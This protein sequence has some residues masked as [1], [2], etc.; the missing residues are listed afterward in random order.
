M[1]YHQRIQRKT[2]NQ[3]DSTFK[4]SPFQTHNFG[5]Q[6]KSSESIPATKVQLWENYQTAKQLHQNSANASLA[7]PAQ[8][9]TLPIQAKL[10]IGKPGDKYEQEAD[11]VAERVMSMSAPAQVQREELPEE[12]LQMKP[13]A[14]TI[15]PL[16]QREELPEEEAELQAKPDENA[17]QREVAPEEEEL[18]MKPVGN[19]I[20]REELP[21]DEEEIQTKQ[22][23]T[24]HSPSGATATPSL[25]NQLSSS[26]GGG[27]PLP[28][29]V[30]S[31]ME[32]R[33]GADFSGVRVHTGSDAVQ[34]NRDVS[35]QAFAH[36]QDVYFGAGKTP[37]K[38]SLTAHELTH[39]IQQ[40][41]MLQKASKKKPRKARKVNKEKG[42]EVKAKEIPTEH[43]FFEHIAHDVAYQDISSFKPS[44]KQKSIFAKSGYD[45]SNIEWLEGSND[46][47]ACLIFP[48]KKYAH[49]KLP[50][51]AVRGTEKLLGLDMLAN[52]DVSQ[53]GNSQFENNKQRIKGLLGSANGKVNIIGHSLGGAVAQIIAAH[54][55]SQ[56]AN[57]VTFQSP[58]INKATLD[59][60]HQTPKRDRP[61]SFHHIAKN[62]I[63]DLAGGSRLDG[64]VYEHELLGI[65]PIAAHEAFLFATKAFKEQRENLSLED[66]KYDKENKQNNLSDNNVAL[67]NSH[68]IVKYDSY[69]HEYKRAATEIARTLAGV[70]PSVFRILGEKAV[71]NGEKA[72]K[73]YE[74]HEKIIIA[75]FRDRCKE[76]ITA[77]SDR[78]KEIIAVSRIIYEKITVEIP[79]F[80]INALTSLFKKNQNGNTRKTMSNQGEG[81]GKYPK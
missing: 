24:P 67:S 7:T 12:E 40:T 59:K 73:N 2:V 44:P 32:P 3:S 66:K 69:P 11:S 17:I 72:V 30:R 39:V 14:A 26:K 20:Q 77:F 58:G 15:S 46:F 60:F 75:A 79:K 6:P 53:V 63:V 4:V 13:L 42:R 52:F 57:V 8:T 34:M 23:P 43:I 68:K 18:Q 76:V 70:I 71:E 54:F 50:I 51:L 25:E 48:L 74:L 5:V 9:L 81:L 10:T 21:E 45:V 61:K 64:T 19:S 29:E 36:G 47:E 28:D 49:T 1:D 56:I 41:G 27:S 38:D 35:A 80:F 78:H 55:T 16:V 22:S 31:F 37:A 65:S 33:F 62:D